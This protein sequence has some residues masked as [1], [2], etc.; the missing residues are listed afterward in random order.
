MI[1]KPRVRF[2]PSPTGELHVGNARTALFNWM[3]A[4]HHNGKFI[5]RIEDTDEARSELSYQIGLYDD[6]K[7]LGLN[8]DEGPEE[9]CPYGPYRQSER[10]PIYKDYLEKLISKGLVYPCYCTEEELEGERRELILSKRMPRYMGKCRNLTK[11]EK[12]R[13]EAQGRNPAFRFKILPQVIEYEDLIRGKVKFE[14]DNIGDFIIVRSNGMPAY[15]F[16]VV[17]DDYLMKISHVIR[18]E[19]H[20]SNTALQLVLYKA[21]G[22]TPP[23]F[24]HHSLILGKDR[25]KLS[26]RHGSVSISEF[27]RRGIMPEALINYLALLGSS[28]KGGKEILSRE[29]MIRE[30]SLEKASKSGAVFDD[31]KLLWINANYIRKATSR[32]LIKDLAP[33]LH[34]AG[35]RMEEIDSDWLEEIINIVKDEMNSLADINSHIEIFFPDKLKMTVEAKELLAKDSSKIIIR[36]LKEYIAFNDDEPRKLY[37]N[38]IKHLKEK[39][40]LKNREILMPI[41]A[42]LTG[43]TKG[44]ELEEVF[45]VMGRSIALELLQRIAD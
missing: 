21:L 2:A 26:K 18:G 22:L 42:A 44:P 25:A 14:S 35:Y 10:L 11:V 41:R 37:I 29:E 24:A 16:S 31:D 8:W 3:F 30:F 38:A 43:K 15:N 23:F 32:D 6:L 45:K 36:Y 33:F 19:D 27:R 1:K 5:L 34:D 9:N 39:T 20:L 17:V 4:R 28:F 13:L 40:R 7:W 12:T